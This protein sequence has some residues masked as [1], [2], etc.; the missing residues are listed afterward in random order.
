MIEKQIALKLIDELDLSLI[1]QKLMEPQPKGMGWSKKEANFF[2]NKYKNFLKLIVKY[3]GATPIVPTGE[4]DAVWHQHILFTRSYFADCKSIFGQYLHHNPSDGTKE[5]KNKLTGS[6]VETSKLYFL[7]F[8]ENYQN[9]PQ[10]KKSLT[11]TGRCR[12]A[13][14]NKSVCGSDGDCESDCQA[15]CA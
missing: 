12:C 3:R 11:V 15:D 2:E 4:I 5:T 7:E 1:M 6:F 10:G 8:G 9:L 14:K 13:L